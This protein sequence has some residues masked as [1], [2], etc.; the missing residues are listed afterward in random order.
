MKLPR[1]IKKLIKRYVADEVVF[2]IETMPNGLLSLN[3]HAKCSIE[4]YLAR[5]EGKE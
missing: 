2:S 1:K 3:T 4:Q 5:Q